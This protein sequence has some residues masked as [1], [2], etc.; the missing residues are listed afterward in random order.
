[1]RWISKQS[2]Q[3]RPNIRKKNSSG[4]SV[5]EQHTGDLETQQAMKYAW[6]ADLFHGQTRAAKKNKSG[7]ETDDQHRQQRVNENSNRD[8]TR[9]LHNVLQ[10]KEN[11]K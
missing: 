5:A 7:T 10:L 9:S 6:L 4:C 11:E 3:Q 2:R 8:L 1:M